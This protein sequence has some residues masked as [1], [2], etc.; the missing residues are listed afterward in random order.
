MPHA[1]SVIAISDGDE[2]EMALL[3]EA[4]LMCLQASELATLSGWTFSWFIPDFTIDKCRL[5]HATQE[6]ATICTAG[7]A[8]MSAL[9][10]CVHYHR[11][12]F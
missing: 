8:L 12:H 1:A 11:S 10:W 6:I 4:G 3:Q 9:P 5:G 2:M 7:Q